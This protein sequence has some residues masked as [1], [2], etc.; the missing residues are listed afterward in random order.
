[1]D[2]NDPKRMSRQ[3]K[4]YCIDSSIRDGIWFTFSKDIGRTAENVV[5]MSLIRSCDEGFLLEE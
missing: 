2:Q 3:K 4:I 5:F 1:M